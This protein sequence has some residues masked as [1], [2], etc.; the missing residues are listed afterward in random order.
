MVGVVIPLL[1]Q[2]PSPMPLCWQNYELEN[3][4]RMGV[5]GDKEGFRETGGDRNQNVLYTCMKPSKDKFKKS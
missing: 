2:K 5:G 3:G 1:S 4:S